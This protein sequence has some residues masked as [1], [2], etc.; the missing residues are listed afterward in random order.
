[1]IV[2]YPLGQ[3]QDRSVAMTSRTGRLGTKVQKRGRAIT[4]SAGLAAATLSMLTGSPAEAAGTCGIGYISRIQI[5]PGDDSNFHFS[6][7]NTGFKPPSIK[8]DSNYEMWFGVRMIALGWNGVGQRWDDKISV[9]KAAY[10]G[11]LPVRIWTS[12]TRC[13]GNIDEFEVTVC[14]DEVQCDIA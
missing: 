14:T 3:G 10:L 5:R 4:L 1:M 8:D 7:D 9:I 13:R 11:R 2:R 6:V 12:G